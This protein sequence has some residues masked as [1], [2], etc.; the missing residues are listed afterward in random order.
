MEIIV[1]KWAT[2]YTKAEPTRTFK[3]IV[4][5]TIV[6]TFNFAAYGC[7]FVLDEISFAS[8]SLFSGLLIFRR[9]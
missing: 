2:K 6:K 5:V 4:T 9:L 3:W 8:L 7:L 1:Q